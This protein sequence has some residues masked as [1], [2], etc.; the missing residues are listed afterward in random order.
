MPLRRRG[1]CRS[2]SARNYVGRLKGAKP[3][4]LPV[5]QSKKFELVINLKTASA[6]GIEVPAAL[7][8]VEDVQRSSRHRRRVWA[9]GSRRQ[10]VRA[11]RRGR[12][13]WQCPHSVEGYSVTHHA[14]FPR[15]VW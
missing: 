14:A 15:T 1:T 4:D 9:S 10:R 12:R 3:G 2:H 8:S 6:L 7:A 5:M 11:G 13:T